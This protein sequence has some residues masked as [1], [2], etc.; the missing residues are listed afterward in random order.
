MLLLTFPTGELIVI[1]NEY[2]ELAIG[3]MNAMR[4]VTFLTMFLM[5]AFLTVTKASVAKEASRPNIVLCMADDQ[6]WGDVG[7][8][9]HPV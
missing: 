1:A 6:G 8:R 7:Y 2:P 3:G 9:G 4:T 5:T